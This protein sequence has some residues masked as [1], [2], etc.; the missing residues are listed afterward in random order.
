VLSKFGEAQLQQ[1]GQ[2]QGALMS[3]IEKLRDLGM[4]RQE[5]GKQLAELKLQGQK[6]DAEQANRDRQY[7]LDLSRLGIERTKENRIPA[8][9][10]AKLAGTDGAL[11][12]IQDA[13]ERFKALKAAG[14][15]THPE[16]AFAWERTRGTFGP[17]IAQGLYD[18]PRAQDSEMSAEFIPGAATPLDVG[19][20]QF[21]S[22]E[23]KVRDRRSAQMQ[24]LAAQ[25]YTVPHP[26]EP[27]GRTASP[28]APSRPPP[29]PPPG[30][31]KAQWNAKLGKYRY[32]DASGKV[33][34]G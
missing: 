1:A 10:S 26:A 4:R 8:Q 28:A 30:A 14:V 2:Q 7:G 18:S 9:E 32:L 21:D 5:F 11:A 19:L 3:G 15:V 6:F 23:K 22:I 33:I 16:Q 17:A 13:R 27:S 20:A 29:Q 34:G 25:G 24:G 31:V 12:A